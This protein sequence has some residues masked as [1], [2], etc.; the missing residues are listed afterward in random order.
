MTHIGI[1]LACDNE[2]LTVAEGNIDNK[3]V[4]G[5]MTRKRDDTVGCYLTA[6]IYYIYFTPFRQQKTDYSTS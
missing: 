5:I 4:S 6:P 2:E 1:V 3:N